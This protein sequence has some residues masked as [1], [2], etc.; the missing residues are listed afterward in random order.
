MKKKRAKMGGPADIQRAVSLH[1]MGVH[2]EEIGDK[3]GRARQTIEGWLR[4]AAKEGIEPDQTVF[5]NEYEMERITLQTQIRDLKAQLRSVR[6]DNLTAQVVRKR[7]IQ[8]TDQTPEPPK[9]LLK[10]PPK[11]GEGIPLTIWSDWH[12]GEVVDPAAVEGVNEYNMAASQERAKQLVQK[13]IYLCD[14]L[15]DKYPGIVVCLGGDM[16]TGDIHDEL[17]ETN[18]LPTM[19]VMLDLFGVLI[20]GLSQLAD[21]FGKVFVPCVAGNHGRNTTKPRFKQHNYSNFDWLLYCLLEKHF[22]SDKRIQFLIPDGLDASF[23]VYDHRFL[24]THGHQLG[25]AGGDGIIGAI[26]PIMRGDFKTRRSNEAGGLPYD[27]LLIGHYHQYIGLD[28]IVVNGSLKGFCE[29]AKYKLR[30]IPEPPRQ[31]LLFVHPEAGITSQRAVNL[32]PPKKI[33]ERDWVS[34]PEK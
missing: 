3:M 9:W 21:R 10:H 30:A 26:G 32:A 17:S 14:R 20:E 28:R 11:G 18:E 33:V 23:S 5:D 2:P 19:P 31:A 6:R 25:T 29:Y 7:I 16:I 4:K 22:Q 12:W 24:L 8:I 13:T 27:T 34:W 1:A 15:G